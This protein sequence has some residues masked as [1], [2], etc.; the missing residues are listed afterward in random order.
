[1]T[2]VQIELGADIRSMGLYCLVTDAEFP[3]NFFARTILIQSAATAAG[4]NP[5]VVSG[6]YPS[7]AT[8]RSARPATPSPGRPVRNRPPIGAVF[9]FWPG[10]L[11]LSPS[12]SG[13]SV[14]PALAAS[15]PAGIAACESAAPPSF[16]DSSWFGLLSL[17]RRKSPNPKGS[18][19]RT[20]ILLVNLIVPRRMQPNE[21]EFFLERKRPKLNSELQLDI[22]Q[23]SR[24][25][26]A[27]ILIPTGFVA[28]DVALPRNIPLAVGPNDTMPDS[29]PEWIHTLAE[30]WKTR[31]ANKLEDT[32]SYASLARKW[33][34][35]LRK[36]GEWANFWRS[37]G[38]KLPFRKRKAEQLIL[39]GEALADNPNVQV[40]AHLP[41]ESQTLY[42]LAELGSAL[43]DKLVREGWI[44]PGMTLSE[45][46]ELLAEHN[47]KKKQKIR[48][49]PMKRLRRFAK[50]VQAG[51]PSWSLKERCLV[52][53]ELLRLSEGISI[54]QVRVAEPTNH[55][56][57]LMN[58]P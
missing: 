23:Q 29:A 26:L 58:N 25:D 32:L 52:K 34:E 4:K 16:G 41:S 10:S 30:R 54:P 55:K 56:L 21:D 24:E 50:F 5:P 14:R 35:T 27:S 42:C 6:S 36:H 48:S 31:S 46:K 49:S 19:F 37:D 18:E 45:A 20:K 44:Y 3:A 13:G 9:Q 2:A 53:A 8:S 47:P 7:R 28:R 51:S 1:M 12:P 33:R 39:V 38:K 11:G 40:R 17:N 57:E 15:V 22:S 43:V